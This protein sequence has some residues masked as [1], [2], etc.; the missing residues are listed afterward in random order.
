M[1]RK[2]FLA[3]AILAILP[4]S[5]AIAEPPPGAYAACSACHSSDGANGVGPTMKGI[6]GRKSGSVG[7]F[8]YSRAMR[9]AGLTWDE[10]SLDAFLADPQQA[11][12]G[13]HMPFPGVADAKQRAEI[14]GYLK[15]VK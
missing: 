3:G 2:L 10:K 7:G 5:R 11:V 13:N 9:S 14:I 6:Y 15:S 1:I 12:P 4:M 8:A